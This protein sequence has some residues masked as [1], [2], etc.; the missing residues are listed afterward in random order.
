MMNES[1]E[2]IDRAAAILARGGLVAFPT[3][4]VY[5]LGADATNAAAVE[6]IFLAKGRPRG[7]PLIVHVADATAARRYADQWPA[8]A[9]K[10]AGR[11]WPGPITIVVKAASCIVPAVTAGLGT[12]GLRAPDHPLAQALLRKF[13]GP[14]AAPS[15]NRSSRISPTTAEHVRRELASSLDLIL[16][17]GPCR[18][19][20]ES[21]VISLAGDVPTILRPGHIE[22][23]SIEAIIGPVCEIAAV[24][25]ATAAAASPGQHAI[26]Y[27]PQSACFRFETCERPVVAA[28]LAGGREAGA[29]MIAMS[30]ELAIAARASGLAAHIMSDNPAD[31]ARELYAVL[32][33]ADESRPVRIWIEMPPDRAP[34]RAVRDRLRRASRPIASPMG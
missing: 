29:V 25:D 7:N 13:D 16:D 27:A 15:A 30:K 5:G 22:R 28:S 18:I 8:A 20:I 33:T 10:L 17:G 31:Y 26:H 34:W 6:R 19:G 1:A 32:R 24:V 21:T 9:A 4:T 2:N 23:A 12:V 14:V 3:E 11:F